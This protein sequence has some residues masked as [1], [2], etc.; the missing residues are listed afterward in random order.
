M[1]EEAGVEACVLPLVTPVLPLKLP[2]ALA[3][4]LAAML[5]SVEL[6]VLDEA[7]LSL[8]LGDEELAVA[9][10][11]SVL[12]LVAATGSSSLRVWSEVELLA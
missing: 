6:C 10:Y 2:D 7:T 5:L 1:L 12:W 4:P 3:E 9:P 11:G 8:E